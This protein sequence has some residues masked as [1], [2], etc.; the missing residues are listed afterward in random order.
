MR[1]KHV[2]VIFGVALGGLVTAGCET[3]QNRY[4]RYEQPQYAEVHGTVERIEVVQASAPSQASGVGMVGGAIVGGLLGNQVG[5]GTGKTLATIAAAAGG[6]YAG[7]EA[8]KRYAGNKE[9]YRV[10]M[11]VPD[12]RVVTFDQPETYNLRVGDRARVSQNR[13]VPE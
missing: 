2:C 7:N 8:E 6:A 13:L 3:Q 10:T 9:I 4:G 1:M 12:G 11:R 5:R